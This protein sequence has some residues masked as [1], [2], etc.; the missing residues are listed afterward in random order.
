[1]IG[2]GFWVLGFRKQ[3]LEAARTFLSEQMRRASVVGVLLAACAVP[4][5]A[6]SK[7]E[8][9]KQDSP[10]KAAPNETELR[11]QLE[12]EYRAELEKRLA[13]ERTSYEGSLRSLWIA[14]GAVWAVLLLFV[15]MQALSARK[16]EQELAKVTGRAANPER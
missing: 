4:V 8:L 2:F 11:K 1:M 5:L 13:Q 3:S 16:R 12:A 7:A 9:M 14:N 10:A 15:M 6:D